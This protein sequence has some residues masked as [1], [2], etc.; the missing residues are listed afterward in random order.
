MRRIVFYFLYY[1][2][3]RHLPRSYQFGIIGRFSQR[4]RYLICRNIIV[5]NRG[6]FRVEKGA[7]FGG[8]KNII[9]DEFGGI[10][11]NARF[12]GGG[13]IVIGKH[14][15]MGPDVMIITDDHKILADSFDGYISKD[16]NIGNYAWIGA[17]TIILKGVK[18]GKYAVIG[19]GSVV[20]HD[21]GDYEIWAGNPA[22]LIRSRKV[23]RIKT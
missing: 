6:F 9:I 8:G 17:R 12:I 3:V 20:T 4:L 18:I 19:A 7:D 1:Y 16:V 23:E 11:E 15:M 14:A 5:N 2:F 21:V 22:R 10:G 13:K